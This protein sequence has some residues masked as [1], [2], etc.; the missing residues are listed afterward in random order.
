MLDAARQNADDRLLRAIAHLTSVRIFD[1][2]YNPL[3]DSGLSMLACLPTLEVLD[4]DDTRIGIDTASWLDQVTR[5]KLLALR[6]TKLNANAFQHVGRLRALT[7][8]DISDTPVTDLDLS[9]IAQLENLK[10]LNLRKNKITNVGVLHLSTLKKLESVNLSQ[11]LVRDDG[12]AAFAGLTQLRE[13]DLTDVSIRGTGLAHLA[14]LSNLTSL[15]FQGHIDD[16]GLEYLGR[17]SQV[18]ELTLDDCVATDAGMEYLAGMKNLRTL[19]LDDYRVTDRGLAVLAEM[20]KLESLGLDDCQ[21]TA[22]GLKSFSTLGA[23]RSLRL[24]TCPIT[25]EG[26]RIIA[27]FDGLEEVSLGDKLRTT[28]DGL[29]HLSTCRN[30]KRLTLY[31]NDLGG[32]PSLDAM[33]RFEH[34]EELSLSYIRM[35][36]EE[37][38][39]IAALPR[40]KS[41]FLSGPFTDSHAGYLARCRSLERLNLHDH[42]DITDVGLRDIAKLSRLKELTMQA[43]ITDE[44]LMSLVA[45]KSL[46]WLNLRSDRLS[47]AGVS[48]L[49]KESPRLM[50]VFT[51]H[52]D[53]FAMPGLHIDRQRLASQPAPDFKVQTFDGQS[54]RLSE[55]RGKVVVLYFWGTWCAPCVATTAK[56]ERVFGDLLKKYDDLV[57]I[58]LSQDDEE[59][60]TRELLSKHNVNSLHAVIPFQSHV[61]EDYFVRGSGIYF[62]VDRQ[63]QVVSSHF[64]TDELPA[65]VEALETVLRSS[66]P[67]GE[68]K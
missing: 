17:L 57:V 44:G 63:G 28:W 45:L 66:E 22:V 52:G 46:E 39:H 62:L 15:R 2:D 54:I 65:Q 26:L 20:T 43:E 27:S 34:L 18:E 12:L 8:L 33:R 24:S 56:R 61:G 64:G 14:E 21:L 32:F 38:Q 9:Q 36:A 49:V 29:D 5:L 51:Q 35:P 40:L 41:V 55:Q 10:H 1:I 3:T 16:V 23:L 4:I 25:D 7:S 50:H 30:L 11:T 58:S 37:F 60:A 31:G 68:S 42:V 19:V 67:K 47:T 13:L 6:R 59:K 53:Y 48:R